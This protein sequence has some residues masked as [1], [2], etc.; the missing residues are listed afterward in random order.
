MRR[1]FPPKVKVAAFLRCKGRC[2]R[3]TARLYPGKYRFN[4]CIP[5]ALDGEPTLENCEVL[6]LSCDSTQT[7]RFDIPRIAKAKRQQRKHLGIADH[8][9]QAFRRS[10][11]KK[12]IGG[13]VVL[14]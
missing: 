7:Y 3:C 9:R 12:K 4:H 8:E 6:C 14:R 13:E 5:D 10:R 11:F 2:E 1:D